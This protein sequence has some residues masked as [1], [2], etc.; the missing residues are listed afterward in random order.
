[1][2]DKLCNDGWDGYVSHMRE[3]NMRL[4]LLGYLKVNIKFREKLSSDIVDAL[5]H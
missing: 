1:M 4:K 5:R 2:Y 3:T